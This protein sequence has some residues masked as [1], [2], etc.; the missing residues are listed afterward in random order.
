VEVDASVSFGEA[1]NCGASHA[2]GSFIARM[3][4]DD[5]YGKDYLSDALLAQRYSGADLVGCYGSFCYLESSDVT[6]YKELLGDVSEAPNWMAR[7]RIPGDTCLL[8]PGATIFVSQAAFEAV[9]GFKPVHIFEDTEFTET[10][11]AAGGRI[12]R[13]HGL[14]FMFRRRDPKKH[15]WQ[16]PESEFVHNDSTCWDGLYFNELMGIADDEEP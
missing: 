11:A 9:G 12:H 2:S 3:D 7:E 4:D 8:I 14:N 1:L 10:I 6:I 16:A 13:T 5:W 15:L